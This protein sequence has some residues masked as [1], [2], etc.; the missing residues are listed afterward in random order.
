MGPGNAFDGYMLFEIPK[1][2][3]EKDIRLLG[4]FASFGDANWKI[5]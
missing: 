4:S 2:T 5:A 3:Q 1:E